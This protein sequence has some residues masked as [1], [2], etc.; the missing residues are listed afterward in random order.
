MGDPQVR[1][2]QFKYDLMTWM[3]WGTPMTSET[4]VY[5]WYIYKW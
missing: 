3:I 5:F 2:F 4:S 1:W